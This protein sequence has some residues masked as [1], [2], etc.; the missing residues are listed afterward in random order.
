MHF[1]FP[2]NYFDEARAGSEIGGEIVDRRHLSDSD[3]YRV[4]ACHDDRLELA[5]T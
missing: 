4:S 3:P 5:G 1:F 2:F